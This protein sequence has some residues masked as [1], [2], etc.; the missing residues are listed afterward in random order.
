MMKRMLITPLLPGL[1]ILSS[2]AMAQQSSFFV[3]PLVEKKV[4]ELPSGDLFWSIATF[5][6][7]E[8][9]QQAAGTYGL[10]TEYD[11]KV[12]LFWLGHKGENATGG[13]E[14]AEI[15][16]I[17]G[18]TAQEYLL[19]INEAGGPQGSVTSVHTHPGSE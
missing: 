5:D 3:K 17:S 2:L 13:K 19:R 4:T 6:T 18:I 1:L 7:K 11:G 15:G 16:P 8:Q 14:V 9:A 12:W 10:V